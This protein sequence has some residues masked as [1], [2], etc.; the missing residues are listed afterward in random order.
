M[1]LFLN[2][3]LQVN[4]DRVLIF[5]HYSGKGFNKRLPKLWSKHSKLNMKSSDF[6]LRFSTIK[7]ISDSILP[8]I[9]YF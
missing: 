5:G 4:S 6:F 9:T 3:I 8:T 7:I 1:Q 2:K